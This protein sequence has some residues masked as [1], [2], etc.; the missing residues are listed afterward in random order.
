MVKIKEKMFYTI[1]EVEQITEIKQHVIRSWEKK[2]PSLAPMRHNNRRLY[3]KKIL[4]ILQNAKDMIKNHGY[5]VSSIE[6][7]LNKNLQEKSSI[8]AI[9]STINDLRQIL[10]NIESAISKLE[11][12]E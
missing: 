7:A 5:K 10:E 8:A 6:M 2:I 1:G 4:Q 9:D 3:S 11:E 12:L